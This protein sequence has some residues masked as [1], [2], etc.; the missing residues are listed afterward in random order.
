MLW[1]DLNYSKSFT[2]GFGIK[3]Q[4]RR[5]V[6]SVAFAQASFVS[7]CKAHGIKENESRHYF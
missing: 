7:R 1:G 3:Q 5:T 2:P 4:T 6:N